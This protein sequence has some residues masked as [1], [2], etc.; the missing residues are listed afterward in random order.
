MSATVRDVAVVGGGIVGAATAVRLAERTRA[1]VLLLEAEDRLAVHQ[2]G[3]NSGVIHSGLYYKP[4]S[5]KAKLCVEGREALYLLCE[6]RGIPHERCGKIVVATS[7]AEEQRL[8]EL[9]IR[10]KKNGLEGLRRLGP[11]GIREIEPHA[12]G[13]A[14]LFVAE[15]GI[16][17]FT[18]VV[19]S[20]A[21]A[22][23]EAGGS[24]ETGARVGSIVPDGSSLVLETPRGEFR[25]RSLVN[26]A[27][28]QAD[29][30]ARLCGID[31]G[32]RIVPFRGMYWTVK[33]ERA[34]LVRNLIYPVPNPDF[35]F[36]GVHFTRRIGGEIEAGPN[37]V[38][39]LQRDGYTPLSFSWPDLRETLAFDGFRSLA[40]RHWK[41]GAAEVY[42]A[43]FRPALAAALRKLVPEIRAQDLEPAG[44]GVRAQA[45][46]AFGNLLD[47]FEIVEAERMLH[48]LN[49]PSPAATASLAIGR[50]LAERAAE[51]FALL[52][53]T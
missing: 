36:L 22:L 13:L 44:S 9:E 6:E 32:V 3:H 14:G 24:I 48:V 43:A 7:P 28:L 47:D 50:V 30:V 20:L 25:A 35:P 33:P 45:V 29:R 26:C 17:D 8:K 5:R 11:M 31:A 42:R 4:G 49:A 16:V 2:T 10:G 18:A 1:T 53:R 52:P 21:D 19:S 51:R 38:L 40:K 37:A 15:T 27:G 23:R 12:T 39:A 34:G 41:T 46:D